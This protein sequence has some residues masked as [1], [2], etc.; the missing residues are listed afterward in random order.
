VGYGTIAIN[1][2]TPT[3]GDEHKRLGRAQERMRPVCKMAFS[4]GPINGAASMGRRSEGSGLCEQ[5]RRISRFSWVLHRAGTDCRN[6]AFGPVTSVEFQL[7]REQLSRE[8][9]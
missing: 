8:I 6:M 4:S 1:C 5:R 2:A 9:L 3:A 7:G